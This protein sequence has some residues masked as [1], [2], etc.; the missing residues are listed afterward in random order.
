MVQDI[1]DIPDELPSLEELTR[2]MYEA[3]RL[4]LALIDRKRTAIAEQVSQLEVLL[5][6][7]TLASPKKRGRIKS[8]ELK[9]DIHE[10]LGLKP[11]S[12]LSGAEILEQ[13]VEQ[14]AYPRTRS[15]R[16]RVYSSLSQWVNDGEP[17]RVDRGVYRLTPT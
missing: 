12:S 16:T 9:K 3:K 4:E 8:D 7:R 5:G 15:L 2:K 1:T 6:L 17:Q 10:I 11:G 14:R 13:L